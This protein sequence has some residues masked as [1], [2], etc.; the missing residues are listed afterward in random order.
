MFT[1]H[2]KTSGKCM[3]TLNEKKY[4]Y[5]DFF[6]LPITFFVTILLLRC[7]KRKGD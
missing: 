5:Q 3:Y 7:D 4:S 1:T 6:C 2:P